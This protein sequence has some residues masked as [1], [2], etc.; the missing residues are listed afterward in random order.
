[1]TARERLAA[2][3][4][5]LACACAVVLLDGALGLEVIAASAQSAGG[6]P[7]PAAE[8][9]IFPPAGCCRWEL[10]AVTGH[11]EPSDEAPRGPVTMLLD[12]CTGRTWFLART[13]R[14]DFEW[15]ELTRPGP[16]WIFAPE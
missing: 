1:M 7:D 9:G 6:G 10:A 13:P 11:G 12:Q 16:P 4:G 15:S 14:G 5:A 8:R 2:L 3:V